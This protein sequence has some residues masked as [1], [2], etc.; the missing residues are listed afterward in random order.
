MNRYRRY[1]RAI[2]LPETEDI[3]WLPT[4]NKID[5]EYSAYFQGKF[6]PEHPGTYREFHSLEKNIRNN[7]L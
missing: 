4:I 3:Y 6:N 1:S 7:K 5:A 2:I